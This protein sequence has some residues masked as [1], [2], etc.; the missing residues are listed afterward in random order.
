[1]YLGFRTSVP[2][3]DI[4][5]YSFLIYIHIYSLYSDTVFNNCQCTYDAPKTNQNN[6]VRKPIHTSLFFV[7]CVLNSIGRIVGTIRL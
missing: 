4:D 5:G 3:F 6:I 1:M 7:Q 2:V